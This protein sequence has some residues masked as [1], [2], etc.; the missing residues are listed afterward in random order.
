M[1]DQDNFSVENLPQIYQN[2]DWTKFDYP[3]ESFISRDG[4]WH[5]DPVIGE[6]E[7]DVLEKDMIDYNQFEKVY[8]AKPGSNDEEN[9]TFLVKHKNGNY[10]FFD[11]GCDYTGFD[12][13]GGGSITY[14][15]D[16]KKM[17]LLGLT[18]DMRNNLSHFIIQ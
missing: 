1:T 9:W 10:V 13:Q 2:I 17:W 3:I 18:D 15:L 11:A 4:S 14:T 12:C 6:E 16:G 5:Y 8:Y 7:S